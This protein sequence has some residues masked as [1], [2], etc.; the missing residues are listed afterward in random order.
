MDKQY[1]KMEYW[2]R[3]KCLYLWNT[4]HERCCI[5]IFFKV[6]CCRYLYSTYKNI[7]KY[8]YVIKTFSKAT[9]QFLFK[10]TTNLYFLTACSNFI[11][12]L[13]SHGKKFDGPHINSVIK[14]S[15]INCRVS[16]NWPFSTDKSGNPQN[17]S[18]P[19]ICGKDIC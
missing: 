15:A 18:C 7:L 13:L 4:L 14:F 6:A 3:Y 16:D 12:I 2:K 9:L 17:N 10:F 19:G 11:K 1:K 8:L 5:T